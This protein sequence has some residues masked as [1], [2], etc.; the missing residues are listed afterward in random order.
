MSA[1]TK[2]ELLALTDAEYQALFTAIAEIDAKTAGLEDVEGISI[3]DI[4]AHRAH[5]CDLLVHWRDEARAG[6]PVQ[7]PAPGFTWTRVKEYN[8]KV[9]ETE[10]G[11]D[12][13]TVRGD[14]VR[15]H[16][17]LRTLIEGT[18]EL[19]L[20]GERLYDWMDDWTLGRW[21]EAS[22]ASHYQSARK[23]IERIL[24]E[25]AQAA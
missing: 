4:I 23:S 7:K 8:A 6:R 15:A 14:F 3:K 9:R 2:A 13:A 17:A 10:R 18:E 5:W 25:R 22:G 12:W 20:Y 11:K 24:K 1:K 19:A 21:A 16:G